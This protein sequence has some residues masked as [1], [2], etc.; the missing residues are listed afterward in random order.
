MSGSEARLA[1]AALGLD[2]GLG[3]IHLDTHHLATAWRATSW[4]PFGLRRLG[5]GLDH[6]RAA[7]ARM[8][9]R[10]ARRHVPFDGIIRSFPRILSGPQ[11][12]VYL[13]K[14]GSVNLAR[15]F[16]SLLPRT[17]VE[18]V[19]PVRHEVSQPVQFGTLFPLYARYL[20]GPPCSAQPYPQ[21]VEHLIRDMNPKWFH[22]KLL[23][24]VASRSAKRAGK[25]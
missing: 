10:T 11:Q 25:D 22:Q 3:F 21:I 8:V 2:P 23:L 18:L 14:A 1:A 19:A 17:P 5:A 7:E 24:A 6:P 13:S 9:L 15:K 16:E 12:R 20:V 4:S